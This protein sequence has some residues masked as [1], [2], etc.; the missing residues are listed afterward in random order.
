[1]SSDPDDPTGPGRERAL[2]KIHDPSAGIAISRNDVESLPPGVRPAVL[3]VDDQ[4][5]RLLTY[6]SILSG[7]EL[8]CV[9]ALSG[10]EAL[11]Q[12]L[13]EEFA[14][15]LLDVSMPGMD[16]FELARL[17]REHPR[18]EK[19]PIIF[20]TG[21]HVSELDRLKGYEVGAIDYISVPVV[22]EILRSKVA[23][24]VEL[25]QR[26]RELRNLNEAL[27]E[28]RKRL[29]AEHASA[30]A[31]REVQLRALFEHPEQISAIVRA[32]R[33]ISGVETDFIVLDVNANAQKLLGRGREE[34]IGKRVSEIP[35]EHSH[36][37]LRLARRVLDSSEPARYEAR[38]GEID[39][40]VTLY[41]IADDTL[42]I[43][44]V[45]V[46]ERNRNQQALRASEEIY[47]LAAEA[48]QGAVYEWDS[49]SDEV[50]WSEGLRRVLGFTPDEGPGKLSWWQAHIH[51]EDVPAF[52]RLLFPES[53]DHESV[54]SVDLRVEHREGHWVY[55]RNRCILQRGSDGSAIR[56]VGNVIDVT[57]I[58]QAEQALRSESER[59]RA[60]TETIPQL[61]WSARP[62]GYSDYYN[63][64]F[65]QY[66]ELDGAQMQGDAWVDTVHPEDLPRAL[67]AWKRAIAGK[68]EYSIEF[69]I[70]RGKDGEYR[71]HLVRGEAL[72]D[73]SGGIVRWFGTCTDIH[74]LKRAER[75]L[76]DS[77][78]RYRTLVEHAPVGVIHAT[79]DG[80]IEYANSALCNLLGYSREELRAKSWQELT[81]PEDLA[82]DESLAGRVLAGELPH[83]TLQKRYLRKDATAVWVELFGTFVFDQVGAPVQGVA[84]VIDL[85]ERRRAEKALR[86]SQD[87][88][89]LA[90]RAARLGTF[91][92]D[93]QADTLRWDERTHELWGVQPS[94]PMKVAAFFSQVHPDDHVNAQKAIDRSFDPRGDHAFSALYRVINRVDGLTRWVE[95]P[96]RVY[97]E[98]DRPSRMVGVVQEVTER[99]LS[100][101]Q[102]A[103]SEQR[104]RELA[105]HID[106]FVWTCELLGQPTWY[107]YRWFEYTGMSPSNLSRDGWESIIHPNHLRR[108]TVSME[109]AL[110]SGSAWEDTF[111]LRGKNG[112]YRWFLG[113]AIP[114]RDETGQIVRWF[115]T[116]TDITE[117]RKLQEALEQADKRKDE[118]LAMLAHE[119]RNPVAP[120]TNAAE[121][122]SR[123]LAEQTSAKP[124]I[125]MI[126]RQALHLSRLLDDL[127]DVARVT[128][129]RIELKKELVTIA[130]CIEPAL[131]AAQ[132]LIR[133]KGH[134]L[135]M[136]ETL[137]PLLVNGDRVRLAQCIAN[138]L[139]NAA[140][141][142]QP[143]GEI[144]IRPYED[145]GHAVI[146]ISDN[147]MGIAP[148][149]QP[150]IFELFVQGERPLDRTQG[151][152]G[153]GLAVCRQLI[154]MHGGSLSASSAGPGCGSRFSIRLPALVQPSLPGRE[155]SFQL[156]PA[157]KIL[158]VDDNQD[159]ADSLAMLLQVEGHE[160][161]CV[162]SGAAGI[163]AFASFGPDVIMLD[164]GL[165]GIDGYE[166]A[167]QIRALPG[168]D[169]VRIIALTGYGQPE[170]RQRALQSGFDDHMVKP[171]RS[172]GVAAALAKR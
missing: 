163:G 30:I 36:E 147:G 20:I 33:D 27:A 6:E 48:L 170:D 17:I 148:E 26:R 1:M 43:S 157:Q 102:L 161:S 146:E 11:Q 77:E 145:A 68:A 156:V 101:Q 127:L 152:L 87:R 95:A 66:L 42:A 14:V 167:R 132:T 86:D 120:I 61:V 59:F 65:L 55:L 110:A 114:I 76:A 126:Q 70:R 4:P 141:F 113:R 93:I 166:V 56:V 129:G 44:A 10:E 2:H 53:L 64:R 47:R 22:T 72:R 109:A 153:I 98:G 165:P 119:L 162:Y 80:R 67:E 28:A 58:R 52:A 83:Y 16:G 130:S 32:Q 134:Q 45:D 150:H 96:G 81:H 111:L 12:L 154:E 160:T 37:L 3:M 138:V 38:L 19:T 155:T 137:Q 115:G 94:G 78:Q 79:L 158:V 23:L 169:R 90:K 108:V 171:V 34:L 172:E 88:L 140:K 13:K 84:V 136:I 122:L 51:P 123:A 54:R 144:R 116:S 40:R 124:L 60:I 57:A 105:N 112:Q 143:R 151:G 29:E 5:A 118:F 133:E 135:I 149:L 128:Q 50:R 49:S 46:T 99:V 9:R 62:D 69:R 103:E 131:E 142:T 21:V 159:A 8:R 164:I 74:E 168:G 18:L 92:W 82:A 41:G 117:Q 7:L 31:A 125:Q 25:H 97:F 91:D 24:L 71:W 63:Q 104:F 107:N 106:Q 89:L 85:N 139:I 15:I 73:S 35:P 121:V 75:S 39:L 100:Q